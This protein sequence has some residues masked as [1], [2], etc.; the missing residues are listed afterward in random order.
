MSTSFGFVL[1][2]IAALYAMVFMKQKKDK[3]K[4]GN[5]FNGIS[6]FINF[7]IV[8]KEEAIQQ[9]VEGN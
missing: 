8:D 6:V 5:D 9:G 3:K 2:V 7:L 1:G 4:S